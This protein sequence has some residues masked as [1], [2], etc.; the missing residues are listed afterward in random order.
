MMDKREYEERY[1]EKVIWCCRHSMS[2]IEGC[3]ACDDEESDAVNS[4]VPF[5]SAFRDEEPVPEKYDY[6]GPP[7]HKEWVSECCGST[8][9]GELDIS[10]FGTTGF[11]GCCKDSAVFESASYNEGA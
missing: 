5:S 11:C 9:I 1:G 10:V 4:V 3:V 2:G 6:I 8:S 7:V